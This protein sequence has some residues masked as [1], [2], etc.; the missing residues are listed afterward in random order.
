MTHP[1]LPHRPAPLLVIGVAV[2]LLW[3]SLSLAQETAPEQRRAA[4]LLAP[5]DA[6]ATVPPAVYRSALGSYR[7]LREQPVGSWRAAN[8]T[9]HGIGG[10]RA[11][12]RE[13]HAPEAAASA[14]HDHASPGSGTERSG[15]GKH[16]H[17][18][19]EAPKG[20]KAPPQPAGGKAKEGGH[21]H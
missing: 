1:S 8:E 14:A 17:A 15:H 2:A 5:L 12:L 21:V 7:A 11:Y 16:K 4:A 20:G 13:A 9:V 19:C 10:W 3:P 6:R 18:C